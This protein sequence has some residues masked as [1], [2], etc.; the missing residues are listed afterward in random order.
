MPRLPKIAVCL[1]FLALVAVAGGEEATLNPASDAQQARARI[2]AMEA[3]IKSLNQRVEMLEKERAA[4]RKTER[5]ELPKASLF[6]EDGFIEVSHRRMRMRFNLT[7]RMDMSADNRNAGN[8]ERLVTAYIPT[9]GKGGAPGASYG[10]NGSYGGGSRFNM[11]AKGSKIEF[12]AESMNAGSH[13]VKVYYLNDFFGSG[14]GDLNYRIKLLYASVGNLTFGKQVLPFEDPEAWPET[15]DAE[16][17]NSAVY[18]RA[19]ALRYDYKMKRGWSSAF[20]ISKQDAGLNYEAT[21]VGGSSLYPAI[22]RVSRIPDISANLRWENKDFGHI[23]LGGIARCIKIDNGPGGD[24]DVMGWGLNIS[25]VIKLSERDTL[26][27]SCTW[28]EGIFSEYND[29]FVE[30]D[31]AYSGEELTALSC[32]SVLLGYTHHWNAKWRSTLSYGLLQVD[33]ESEAPR[34]GVLNNE[35]YRTQYAA[36]NVIWR[37]RPHFDIGFEVLYGHLKLRNGDYGDV[38]RAQISFLYTLF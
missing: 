9:K 10:N 22:E 4:E 14:S 34:G 18:S 15:V 25:S 35:Y 36:A 11:N 27:V 31:V 13:K 1:F 24:Q 6:T 5:P 3:T 19:V 12:L 38:F 16:G 30:A 7:L 8:D 23:M 29:D 2:E 37:A 20:A 28:G 21:A 33:N 17:V 32:K 26:K